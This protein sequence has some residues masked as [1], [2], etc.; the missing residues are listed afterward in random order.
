ML[1]VRSITNDIYN[2]GTGKVFHDCLRRVFGDVFVALPEWP[3]SI[4][5]KDSPLVQSML[6]KLLN[7][8]NMYGEKD[9]GIL[10][11]IAAPQYPMIT[12]MFLVFD[13]HAPFPKD[14]AFLIDQDEPAQIREFFRLFISSNQK[15]GGWDDNVRV[16]ENYAVTMTSNLAP[17]VG[18]SADRVVTAF[19]NGQFQQATG[20]YAT[21]DDITDE[22]LIAFRD[23]LRAPFL[24]ILTEEQSDYPVDPVDESIKSAISET[25][26]ETLAAISALGLVLT[27]KMDK[28][29]DDLDKRPSSGLS[30]A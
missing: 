12:S 5:F 9:F 19:S 13:R 17:I 27:T 3:G 10:G 14:C 22:M 30:P 24:S 20:P 26:V 16:Y 8:T 2:G 28:L 7:A 4:L 21:L 1:N 18:T 6:P 23:R 11:V 29:S 15:H 25:K